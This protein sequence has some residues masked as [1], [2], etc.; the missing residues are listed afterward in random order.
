[1]FSFVHQICRF[2]DYTSIHNL[3][4]SCKYL[5]NILPKEYLVCSLRRM[6]NLHKYRFLLFLDILN[7]PTMTELYIPKTFDRLR[8][9]N[10]IRCDNLQMVHISSSDTIKRI[11]IHFCANVKNVKIDSNLPKLQILNLEDTPIY[12]FDIRKTWT[13]LTSL[14]L[15]CTNIEYLYVP[16]EC[17]LSVINVSKTPIKLIDF[18]EK[19]DYTTVVC[20]N[21]Y[22]LKIRKS[23]IHK[24]CAIPNVVEFLLK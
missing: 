8:E 1:M 12:H 5:D 11:D 17:V 6:K 15:V 10:I 20:Y 22:Q 7:E 4:L 21:V 19:D 24:I 13:T 2:S 9:I 18:E 3:K 23:K 14:N 16:Q